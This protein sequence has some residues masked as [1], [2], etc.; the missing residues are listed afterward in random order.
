[1]SESPFG[2]GEPLADVRCSLANPLTPAQARALAEAGGYA[3]TWEVET[4]TGFQS[5]GW[6][7]TFRASAGM[8]EGTV[9]SDWQIND[10]SVRFTV[11]PDGDWPT[12]I[13]ES[14][15]AYVTH[16]QQGC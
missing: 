4:P 6:G 1:M 15:G 8:P 3:V 13:Q 11:R 9:V 12:M 10:H 14:D 2:A 5:D 7:G 16:V